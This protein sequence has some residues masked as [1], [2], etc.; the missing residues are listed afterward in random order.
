MVLIFTPMSALLILFLTYGYSGV[1]SVNVSVLGDISII[2][3]FYSTLFSIIL[4]VISSS[5]LLWS[6]SYMESDK[7]FRRFLTLVF[8]FLV[9]MLILIYFPSIVFSIIGWGGLGLSSFFLVTYY[10]NRKSLSSGMLTGLSNRVGDI[11]F[12]LLIP[13][14]DSM[15]MSIMVMVIFMILCMTKSAQFPFSAWLPAAMA[16]PTP[17]SALVH[18]STL[19][20]AGVYLLLRFNFYMFYPLLVI[21]TLTMLIAGY[22]ACAETDV[23][24]I[25]ALSTL[26]QL[27]VMFV[28]LGIGQKMLCYFHLLTH[29]IFK[30][31]LFIS[32]GMIIHCTFGSQESRAMNELSNCVWPKCFLVMGSAALSGFPFLAGFYSK[33]MILENFFR[34]LPFLFYFFFLV[35]IGLTVV[36]STKLVFILLTSNLSSEAI[37]NISSYTTWVEKI[38]SITLG[39][40]MVTGGFFLSAKFLVGNQILYSVDMILPLIVTSIGIMLGTHLSYYKS[41][42]TAHSIIHLSPLFQLTSKCTE[43][44][45]YPLKFIDQGLLEL[46]GP[47]GINY[48]GNYMTS[49]WYLTFPMLFFSGF[50]LLML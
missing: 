45:E 25:I 17:V 42:T 3:D 26:S 12:L 2:M 36:Y 10:S 46:I 14:L 27:G 33:D 20:T 5:V 18:S 21:G 28:A 49:Y 31:L 1:L 7:N 29:A 41:N 8:M 39:T 35:G 37:S 32:V 34:G 48:F 11:F 44:F 9:S 23:K 15:N 19:V 16:A 30:A 47:S 43:K 6:Y 24:K 50:L 38:P 4:M 40:M 22:C 13:F